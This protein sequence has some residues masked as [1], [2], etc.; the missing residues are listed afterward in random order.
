MFSPINLDKYSPQ[1]HNNVT[2]SYI[3]LDNTQIIHGKLFVILL[4]TVGTKNCTGSLV[5]NQTQEYHNILIYSHNSQNH[6]LSYNPACKSAFR[7]TLVTTLSSWYVLISNTSHKSNSH[8]SLPR[9]T[10]N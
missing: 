4:W 7:L 3:F 5:Y 9:L 8:K 1:L 10:R 2:R 6:S